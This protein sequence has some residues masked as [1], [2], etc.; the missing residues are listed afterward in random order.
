MIPPC[1]RIDDDLNLA[2]LVCSCRELQKAKGW[3]PFYLDCRPSTRREPPDR[4][5]DDSRAVDR[6]DRRERFQRRVRE[7]ESRRVPISG[8]LTGIREVGA[9]GL[10]DMVCRPTAGGEV[11]QLE[12]TFLPAGHHVRPAGQEPRA[13]DLQPLH[14]PT[15]GETNTR[16]VGRRSGPEDRGRVRAK[17][18][19]AS[20]DPDGHTGSLS[21]W[22]R[23]TVRCRVS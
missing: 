11:A 16:L 1:A 10:P 8:R 17:R 6:Q 18:E 3:Q 14:R 5:E 13:D 20:T 19:A 23:F 2:L 15:R 12:T 7:T 21:T 22:H 9:R 4:S